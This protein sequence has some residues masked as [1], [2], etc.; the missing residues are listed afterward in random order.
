MY[1]VPHMEIVSW[2]IDRIIRDFQILHIENK[3]FKLNLSEELENNR[4]NKKRIS[5]NE[6]TDFNGSPL[7][8][9]IVWEEFPNCC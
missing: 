6:Q 2:N 9:R 1:P 3:S 5:L 8:N 7:L 4:F